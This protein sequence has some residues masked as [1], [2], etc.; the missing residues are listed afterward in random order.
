MHR[1]WIP[2]LV[3][4]ERLELKESFPSSNLYV[5][6]PAGE[7]VRSLY[8]VNEVVKAIIENN[9]YTRIRLVSAGVKVF[10]R[11][12]GSK[13]TEGVREGHQFR[14]LN[15]GL[16]A[17]LPYVREETLLEG[18]ITALKQLL[19]TYYPLTAGFEEEFRTMIDS[20]RKVIYKYLHPVSNFH[21][22]T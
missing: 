13:N 18:K 4:R 6:N 16:L 1:V 17:V 5:R 20:K 12:E 3:G 22:F 19:E 11:S 7:P 8:L 2:W 10:G 9:E 21:L 14:A 15:E